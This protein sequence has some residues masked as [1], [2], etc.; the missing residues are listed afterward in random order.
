M[1]RVG[2]RKE[3]DR[4]SSQSCGG[5]GMKAEEDDVDGSKGG[6]FVSNGSPARD[7]ADAWGA[8]TA[9]IELFSRN[10]KGPIADEAE[11]GRRG[12]AHSL[13]CSEAHNTQ[14]PNHDTHAKSSPDVKEA[15]QDRLRISPSLSSSNQ[16]LLASP[17]MA[18]LMLA[19]KEDRNFQL[20]PRSLAKTEAENKHNKY[21]HFCQ[22]I[23]VKKAR[24]MRACS[25]AEC[26]RR[27]C[28]H[29]LLFHLKEEPES[30]TPTWRCPI[31][32]R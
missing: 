27:F 7:D 21:C 31:C 12:D 19:S 25:N 20:S 23:K 16:Q 8:A 28:E 22:H 10:E 32:R 9:L 2:K 14:T 6:D 30:M 24:S 26:A 15:Q 3:E 4:M 18:N 11:R 5:V 17:Y 29:C 13:R 1:K